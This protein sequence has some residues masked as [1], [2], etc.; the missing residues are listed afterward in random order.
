MAK[1]SDA[2]KKAIVA[3]GGLKPIRALATFG[4]YKPPSGFVPVRVL[5]SEWEHTPIECL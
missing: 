3:E 1:V 4:A 2:N 5:V